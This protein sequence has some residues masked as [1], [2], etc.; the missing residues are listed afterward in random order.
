MDTP[1]I[2]QAEAD[3]RRAD[4]ARIFMEEGIF[5]DAW[6]ALEEMLTEQWR[7]SPASSPEI[8]EEAYRTLRAMDGLRNVLDGFVQ[9]GVMARYSLEQTKVDALV[10]TQ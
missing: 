3:I 9:S 2:D 1:G 4:R 6:Q 8:R 7:K 5:Q 10:S